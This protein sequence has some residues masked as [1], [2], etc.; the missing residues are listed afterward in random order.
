MEWNNYQTST[1]QPV[2]FWNGYIISSHNL[3]GMSLFI[4]AGVKDKPCK[5]GPCDLLRW[6]PFVQAQIKENI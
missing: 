3:L 2:K 1:V 5:R 6:Y 4:Y